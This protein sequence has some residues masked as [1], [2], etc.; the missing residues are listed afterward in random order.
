MER[1]RDKLGANRHLGASAVVAHKR[2]LRSRS[3]LGPDLVDIQDVAGGAA[4]FASQYAVSALLWRVNVEG[5]QLGPD[6]VDGGIAHESSLHLRLDK[7][8]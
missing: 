5:P 2:E 4:R 7:Q 1:W 3:Q 8:F 6:L